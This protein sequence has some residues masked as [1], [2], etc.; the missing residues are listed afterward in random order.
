MTEVGPDKTPVVAHHFNNIRQQQDTQRFGIWL[1][2]VT[3]VLFF[4]GV[5][6]AYTA[7]RIWYPRDFEAG[8]TALNPLIASINSFILLISSFTA[9]LGVRAAYHGSRSGLKLWLAVTMVLG[10]A[11]LG[12]KAR[13][14]AEDIRE[15]LFPSPAMTTILEPGPDGRPVKRTVSVFSQN[16][17]EVLERKKFFRE[18][19]G[20][21][22]EGVDFERVQLF[23]VFY[24]TMTGLHV[25]H[26]I[27]GIGLFVWQYVLASTG[28][29]DRR[30]RY[31][32]VQ[33]LSLYWHFVELVWIFLL[34]L[35]YMA[36]HHQGNPLRL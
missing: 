10:L 16:V 8:S 13:E 29:F 4:G 36:G 31:I 27:I 9:M 30:E 2:L 6:C 1:F 21:N 12:F 18:D 34:P 33:V 28:Y 15:G 35:L 20:K 32:Y 19:G 5:L 22:L 23:F 7:Y 11:F 17:R 26:M 25:L 14:Y 3:E 24:W